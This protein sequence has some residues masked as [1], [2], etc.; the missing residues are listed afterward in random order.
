MKTP[1]V[2]PMPS[3]DP[4]RFAGLEG[5]IRTRAYEL[6]EERGKED[7]RDLDDWFQAEAEIMP[8]K[9]EQKAS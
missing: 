7:G 8:H 1:K 9:L 4:A 5:E 6:Y 2:T 3:T